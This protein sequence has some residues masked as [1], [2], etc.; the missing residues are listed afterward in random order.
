LES[1]EEGEERTKRVP[2]LGR[3]NPLLLFILPNPKEGRG[4]TTMSFIFGKK[5][6]PAGTAPPSHEGCHKGDA[7]SQ[8]NLPA[9]IMSWARLDLRQRRRRRGRCPSSLL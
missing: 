5:K 6:T 3:I 8:M 9:N 7:M 1:Q 4:T 2:L